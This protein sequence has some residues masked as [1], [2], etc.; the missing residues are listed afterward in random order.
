MRKKSVVVIGGGSATRVVLESLRPYNVSL[1]AVVSTADSGGSSGV[2]RDELGIPPVGDIRQCLIALS[3]LPNHKKKLLQ[4]RFREGSLKGHT[5]GNIILAAV[6]CSINDP[7]QAIAQV[8]EMWDTLGTVLPVTRKAT[9][10]AVEFKDGTQLAGEKEWYELTNP[11]GGVKKVVLRKN[12]VLHPAAVEVLHRADVI[13]FSPGSLYTSVVPCLLVRGMKEALTTTRAQLVA[14]CPL[15]TRPAQTDGFTVADIVRVYHQMLGT[16]R[17]DAL[18][19]NSSSIPSSVLKDGVSSR[20]ASIQLQKRDR[21]F[22][23]QIRLYEAKLIGVSSIYK[24][25]AGDPMRRSVL[26]HDRKKLGAALWKIID[27][28]THS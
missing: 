7:V 28:F 17:L 13:I 15:M 23:K 21:E 6:Y 5:L 12:Q 27:S 3:R 26:G 25:V 24:A 11:H 14:V 8:G 2:L 19:V 20:E 9:T 4:Y 22:L 16:R 18:V 10:L 1:T